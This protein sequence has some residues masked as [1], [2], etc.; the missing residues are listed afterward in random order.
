M[1]SEVNPDLNTRDL[2]VVI[3]VHFKQF[4][5]EKNIVKQIDNSMI[6]SKDILLQQKRQNYDWTENFGMKKTC[7]CNPKYNL[8]RCFEFKSKLILITKLKGYFLVIKRYT[9]NNIHSHENIYIFVS[10]MFLNLKIYNQ[11]AYYKG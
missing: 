4:L 9:P 7:K 10:H 5:D 6:N 3:V 8:T 2:H 1:K 11:R